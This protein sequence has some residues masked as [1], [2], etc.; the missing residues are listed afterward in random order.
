MKTFMHQITN[1]F[2]VYQRLGFILSNFYDL[3][4]LAEEIRDMGSIDILRRGFLEMSQK[5]FKKS[6]PTNLKK[7]R[8]LWKK[9][10]RTICC[11]LRQ[12]Q[13]H[14]NLK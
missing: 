5:L 2:S 10:Y 11:A 12:Q 8:V 4:Y 3:M 9:H 13:K 7:T 6:V 1:T 14:Q